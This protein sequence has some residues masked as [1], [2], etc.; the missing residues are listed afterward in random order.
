MQIRA[1]V[2]FA[3][4]EDPRALCLWFVRALGR[5]L[6]VYQ[7]TAKRDRTVIYRTRLREGGF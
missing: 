1:L 6:R 7:A 3:I 2:D 4:D 5:V